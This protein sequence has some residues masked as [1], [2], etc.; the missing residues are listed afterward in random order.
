LWLLALSLLLKYIGKKIGN[1]NQGESL[2]S[3][4]TGC[5]PAKHSSNKI[6][7]EPYIGY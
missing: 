1:F 2:A 6:N 4:H 5:G 3:P 7:I